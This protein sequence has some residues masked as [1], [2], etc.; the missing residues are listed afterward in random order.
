[1]LHLS[2]M[3]RPPYKEGPGHVFAIHPSQIQ[4][5]WPS[6]GRYPQRG[7]FRLCAHTL[8][9][10]SVTWT[11]NTSSCDL[12]CLLRTRWAA[13]PFPP[14]THTWSL[15]TRCMLLWFLGQVLW[16]LGQVYTIKPVQ[17]L[18]NWFRAAIKLYNGLL[19]SLSYILYIIYTRSATV[20]QDF[21]QISSWCLGLKHIG[22]RT[23]CAPL[24]DREA[25]TH[26]YKLPCRGTL[27]VIQIS[28]LT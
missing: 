3:G 11:H 6:S 17:G 25:V 9:V 22:L 16:F 12:K 27:F 28:L 19:S 5:I 21:T 13:R 20:N 2:S 24:R 18:H 14:T 1:M 23:F 7:R 10:E 15:S 8:R 4:V 26:M